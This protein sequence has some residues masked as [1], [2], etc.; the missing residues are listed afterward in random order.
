MNEIKDVI[1]KLDMMA[2]NLVGDVAVGNKAAI[3]YYEALD[4]AISVL[5]K[6]EWISVMD[7]LPEKTGYYLV[8]CNN[9]IRGKQNGVDI[10]YYQH[11]ARNWKGMY[12]PSITHWM[13]FP[14][15][16]IEN[17]TK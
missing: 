6:K 5:S 12:N 11:K 7:R 1:L 16:P 17:K 15:P 9:L 8:A 3:T 4:K 10:S 14:L 13:L 2:T